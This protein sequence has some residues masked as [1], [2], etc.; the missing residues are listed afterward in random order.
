MNLRTLVKFILSN[1][2]VF[3]ATYLMLCLGSCASSNLKYIQKSKPNLTAQVFAPGFISI[4]SLA[5]F[6]SVF[7]KAGDEFYYALDF[8]GRAEIWYSKLEAKQWTKPIAIISDEKYSFNDPMLSPDESKLYYISNLPRLEKDSTT[9]ID[10]WYS[11]RTD[12]GWSKAIHAG[13]N[14]NSTSNDYYI[15][16][17]E[18]GSMYYASN[19]AASE[20]R[21]HDFDIY[22]SVYLNGEFQKGEKISEAINTRAYEADVFIAPDESYIIFCSFRRSGLG[23]GDLYISFKDQNGEWLEAVNMGNGINTAAYELCPFIS[24]D[25][26][27]FFYTSDQDIYW[28]STEIIMQLKAKHF[29]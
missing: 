14:I 26:K 12:N 3:V 20:K 29:E 17:T 23:K 16:F 1:T 9:D 5:E 19:K 8:E 4:D 6:G 21:K 27:Y 25:G 28:V 11:E 22:R 24:A 18:D 13:R 2:Y 7:N 10:I 15:S